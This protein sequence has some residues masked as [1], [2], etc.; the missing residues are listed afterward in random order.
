MCQ[1]KMRCSLQ[2]ETEAVG[3]ELPTPGL[4][5]ALLLMPLPE[6]LGRGDASS[7]WYFFHSG[8]LPAPGEHGEG[9]AMW[10]ESARIW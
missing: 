9:Q 8:A 5:L 1:G 7:H 2:G 4:Q 10:G 3:R 6:Q